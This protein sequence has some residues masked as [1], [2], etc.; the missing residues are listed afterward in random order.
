MSFP[1]EREALR[2]VPVYRN[3]GKDPGRKHHLL[4]SDGAILRR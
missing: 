2:R 1:H 4:A 3:P